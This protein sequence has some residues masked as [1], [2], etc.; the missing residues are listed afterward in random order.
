[1]TLVGLWFWR[2]R[3][4]LVVALVVGFVVSYF[5]DDRLL[6]FC[7]LVSRILGVLVFGFL[8]C[9]LLDSQVIDFLAPKIIYCLL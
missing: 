8:A 3:L 9:C 5:S 7:F 1:M 6:G 2:W 4:A